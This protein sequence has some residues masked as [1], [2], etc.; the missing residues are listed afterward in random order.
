MEYDPGNAPA[1][2]LDSEASSS[3]S[4]DN[5]DEDE[6]EA[7]AAEALAEKKRTRRRLKLERKAAAEAAGIPEK[8]DADFIDDTLKK[9]SING[10]R[11][12]NK[13]IAQARG[14]SVHVSTLLIFISSQ[15][16]AHRQRKLI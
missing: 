6:D 10:L 8:D 1:L 9:G 3:S 13:S 12:I 16:Y 5:E 14:F 4:A 15:L 7:D 11:A 2:D